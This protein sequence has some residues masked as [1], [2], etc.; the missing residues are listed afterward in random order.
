MSSIWHHFL[1]DFLLHLFNLCLIASDLK[2]KQFYSV[3]C[4][5]LSAHK[6]ADNTMVMG[7]IYNKKEAAYLDEAWCRANC[8][9]MNT[10]KTKDLVVDFRKKQQL[11]YTHSRSFYC[12]QLQVALS[13]HH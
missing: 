1:Y 10:S 13:T 4:S 11:D 2:K 7:L 8:L 6:F 12:G 5:T 3:P 9:S